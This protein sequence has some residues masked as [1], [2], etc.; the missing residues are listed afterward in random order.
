[1]LA[2]C[3]ERTLLPSIPCIVAAQAKHA[4]RAI[5]RLPL[6]LWPGPALPAQASLPHRWSCL[7]SRRWP[8][9]SP[10]AAS[11]RGLPCPPLLPPSPPPLP[12]PPQDPHLLAP[13]PV[14]FARK[15][16]KTD[17]DAARRRELARVADELRSVLALRG[18]AGKGN[19]A[20]AAA[21]PA[22]KPFS[23]GGGLAALAAKPAGSGS[24][25]SEAS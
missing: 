5:D 7:W 8:C 14:S 12:L 11:T 10:C 15:P 24:S 17:A 13:Q 1:M 9:Q 18:S 20:G 21:Q 23:G 16:A 22:G 4:R 3:N 2:S 19:S 6:P 25:G